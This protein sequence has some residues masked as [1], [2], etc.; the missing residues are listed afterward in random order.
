MALHK[1]QAETNSVLSLA[2]EVSSLVR[3]ENA[4]EKNPT[5][6]LII[7]FLHSVSS[8]RPVS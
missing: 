2:K 8:C 1:S 7:S 5:H 4:L 6:F 3:S